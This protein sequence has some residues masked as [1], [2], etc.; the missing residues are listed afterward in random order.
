MLMMS[1]EHLHR[2]G[3]D[4]LHTC[5]ALRYMTGDGLP[6][7]KKNVSCKLIGKNALAIPSGIR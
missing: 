4:A 3:D 1:G 7:S 2:A 6:V 5:F